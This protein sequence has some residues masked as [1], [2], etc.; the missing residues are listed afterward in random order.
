MKS[1]NQYRVLQDYHE[2]YDDS[3]T[4]LSLAKEC[5]IPRYMQRLAIGRSR[6]VRWLASSTTA[7]T[8]RRRN[9]GFKPGWDKW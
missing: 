7:T 3:R 9:R 1:V 6:N 8:E 4:H 5:L 2:Y